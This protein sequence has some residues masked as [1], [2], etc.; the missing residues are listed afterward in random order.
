MTDQHTKKCLRC[1]QSLPLNSF[2]SNR[3]SKDGKDYYCK[4]CASTRQKE[5]H[6]KRSKEPG[7]VE[8]RNSKIAQRAR[9]KKALAVSMFGGSCYDCGETYPP[10]VM[11]FH[12]EGDKE[13]NPSHFLGRR[14][15][16][17]AIPELEKCVL[18]CANCH[19]RR[20]FDKELNDGT[21][22]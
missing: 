5:Y 3:G 9:D 11:D 8:K 21:T 7:Y 19:R 18:L 10:Y 2:G 4:P 17:A 6:S 14:S 20:H 13:G 22:N 16:Q 1:C 15:L 12:H